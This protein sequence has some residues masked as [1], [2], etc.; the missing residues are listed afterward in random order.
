MRSPE[1]V[2]QMVQSDLPAWCERRSDTLP[3]G[4]YVV[5]CYYTRD[6]HPVTRARAERIE[7]VEYAPDGTPLRF[8]EGFV[9]GLVEPVVDEVSFSAAGFQFSR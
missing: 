6:G 2:V 3:D 9:D 7:L 8:Q 1:E 5:A 4:R